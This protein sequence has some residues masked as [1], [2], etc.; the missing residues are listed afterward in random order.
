MKSTLDSEEPKY[1][2]TLKTRSKTHVPSQLEPCKE[3][4]RL[5]RYRLAFMP[6]LK[7]L[8]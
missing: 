2:G 5:N 6:T 7:Q 1:I 4:C 8:P 3:H